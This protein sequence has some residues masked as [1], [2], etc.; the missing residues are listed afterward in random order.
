MAKGRNK[1]PRF[2]A[3]SGK[4]RKKSVQR[5]AGAS[6]AR[7]MLAEGKMSRHTTPREMH[8]AIGPLPAT[9]DPVQLLL[10]S[11]SFPARGSLMPH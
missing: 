8:H 9:R 3:A 7:T 10:A 5:V 6:A 4:G 2:V 1:V 11:N